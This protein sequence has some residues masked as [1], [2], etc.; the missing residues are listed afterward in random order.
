MILYLPGATLQLAQLQ[1]TIHQ[2]LFTTGNPGA[3]AGPANFIAKGFSAPWNVASHGGSCYKP[4]H[5]HGIL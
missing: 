2:L 1:V 3:C 5:A 4:G